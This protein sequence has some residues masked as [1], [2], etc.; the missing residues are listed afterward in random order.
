[1]FAPTHDSSMLAA[2]L[3]TPFLTIDGTITPTGESGS[4]A[5]SRSC[6]TATI[7]PMTLPTASGVA[8]WGVGMR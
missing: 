5:P 4:G 2:S 3:V 8:G 6:S 1:M 7:S